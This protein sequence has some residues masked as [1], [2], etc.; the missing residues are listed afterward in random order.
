MT[1]ERIEGMRAAVDYLAA[2]KVK[3]K[4]RRNV[5][6]GLI[7]LAAIVLLAIFYPL[8]GGE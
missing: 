1:R 6:T 8:I 3:K 2:K 5:I 7:F 4:M